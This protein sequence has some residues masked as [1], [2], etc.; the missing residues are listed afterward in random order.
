MTAKGGMARLPGA[1]PMGEAGRWWKVRAAAAWL[2]ADLGLILVILV[3][4]WGGI[5]LHLQREHQRTLDDAA[6]NAGNLAGAA[7][8][9]IAR[10][11]EA[12]DQRLLFI[13]EA[14]RHDPADFSLDFLRQE[15]GFQQ[16]MSLQTAVIGPSGR[17]WL[18]NLG[19]VQNGVDLSDRA[20]FR[21]HLDPQQ[22]DLFISVPVMGRESGRWSVQFTRKLLTGDGRFGGVV[23]IS[24]NPYWLTQVYD[25]LDIGHG[26]VTLVGLDGI[27]RARAPEEAGT[28]GSSIA[29]GDLMAEALIRPQG[30]LRSLGK[31]DGT[32]RLTAFRRVES[33]PLIVAVSNDMAEILQGY[34]AY[35]RS[36]LSSGAVLTLLILGAG[37][38][39]IRRRKQRARSQQ[40]LSD[41]IENISQ[42]LVMVAPDGRMPVVNRRAMDLLG[43]PEGR[44]ASFLRA[45][46]V[47]DIL[48]ED[49]EQDR[50]GAA[51][52][53]YRCTRPD[54]TVL[55]VRSQVLD[56][57]G[58]VRTF[59]DVTEQTL[60]ERRVRFLAHH[61]P[62]TGLANRLLLHER[63]GAAIG[64][65]GG[66]AG[67]LVVMALDLDRFKVVNDTYGHAAG[68]QL[69][70]QVAERLGELVG[71]DDTVSRL[72]GD[73]FV[74]LWR[75]AASRDGVESLARR[76]VRSLVTPFI[77]DGNMAQVGTSVGIALH[78]QDGAT[79]E[80][81][82]RNA[83]TALYRAKSEGRGTVRFFEPA[84]ELELRERREMEQDLRLALQADVLELHY[85]PIMTCGN[86]AIRGFEALLRWT[87]PV[88]GSVPPAIFIPVAEESGLILPLGRWVMERACAEAATWPEPLRLAV[89]LSP[90]Q[91]RSGNLP[92]IVDRALE[93]SGLP[94]E[95]LELE[96]TEGLLIGDAEE[97]LN[98]IH[99][100]KRRG[101]R[102]ALDDFGTGYA[103]LGYL[104]RFPFDRIKVDRSF[105]HAIGRRNGAHAIVEAV[106]AMSSNLG[107]EVTAE[108]VE[109]EEQLRFLQH[110]ACDEVQGFLLGRPMSR[111]AVAQ[112][113]RAHGLRDQRLA[114][115]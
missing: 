4:F 38:L 48:P 66:R 110:R 86:G 79:P 87:H 43:V 85:Q 14:Y 56:N 2:G 70:R 95:R 103:S 96:I 24:L 91:F 19:P 94:A 73:E 3:L 78:P 34:D 8:Q 108:G 36:I 50:E 115:S 101:V 75:G 51:A 99:A 5:A 10:T 13:R 37:L 80:S 32:G 84:M 111:E 27:I 61:D 83:D 35:R 53:L 93:L 57:G 47:R 31:V 7:Q 107:M 81:L 92:A 105:V 109:T 64:E 21:V 23:V 89:N 25:T 46:R 88:R 11:V 33:F 29:G 58:L 20:H 22:D 40:A 71:P 60:S 69:L 67:R 104:H 113:L 72:G 15:R 52:P 26:A 114:L 74:I 112:L 63:L 106:L 16:D 41:A 55:E 65:A 62:L 30:T 42:G 54:G 39:L 9:I 102:I 17:L 97:A 12:I 28:L 68:D 90:A 18:S 44:Q 45:G 98:A 82:L 6:R 49:C 59:T 76:I 77:L 100:L 1:A